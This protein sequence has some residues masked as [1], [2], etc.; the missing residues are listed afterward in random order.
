MHTNKQQSLQ[1]AID[2]ARLALYGASIENRLQALGVTYT[3]VA[4]SFRFYA[5]G[6]MVLLNQQL[7]L[8]VESSSKLKLP[9]ELQVVIY[10]CLQKEIVV[11]KSDQMLA[12]VDMAAGTFYVGPYKQRTIDILVNR[13]ADDISMLQNALQLFE[14][15]AASKGDVS[16]FIKLIGNLSMQLTDWLSVTEFPAD[17]TIVYSAAIKKILPTEDVVVFT[18]LLVFDLIAAFNQG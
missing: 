3:K 2:L 7:E 4:E 9:D 12:F 5:F 18:S 8:S 1:K 16:V 14:C 10:H 13:V 17:A 6:R 11:T 15:T